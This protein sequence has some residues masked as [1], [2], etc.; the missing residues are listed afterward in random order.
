MRLDI[1]MFS[2]EKLLRAITRQV[3]YYVRK[4]AA[5]VVTLAG[6]PFGIF[7]GENRAHGFEHRLADEIFGGDQLQAFVLA[8]SFIVNSRCHLRIGLIDWAGHFI[9]HRVLSMETLESV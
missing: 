9:V 3:F 6:I 5:A 8:P 7:V 4:L 2:T 1:S